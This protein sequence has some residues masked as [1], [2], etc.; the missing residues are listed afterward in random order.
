M[1]SR[2]HPAHKVSRA[3]PSATS[4][5]NGFDAMSEIARRAPFGRPAFFAP[6]FMLA[7]AERWSCKAG[8]P[9]YFPIAIV[10]RPVSSV[11][12]F[13]LFRSVMSQFRVDLDIFRGPLDL[14]LYLVRKHELD[15][16]DIRIAPSPSS[17]SNTSRCWSRSTSMRSAIFS[18]WPALLIEIKSRMVLPGD[19]EVAGGARRPAAGAGPPAA[20]VQAVPRRGQH[21]RRAQPRVAR[22][23]SAAG[24]RPAGAAA[25]A[26]RAADSGSRAVG[27]GERVRPRAEGEARGR[28][29]ENIRYDDTPIHVYMQRI[30][31]RLR[32]DGRV[33]FTAFF[34]D[35]VHKS[36][37]VGMFLA[38]LELVRHQHARAAQPELFGEIWLEP[39]DEAAAGGAGRGGRLR[40]WRAGDE[41]DSRIS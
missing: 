41:V 25:V 24:E 21:A 18:R 10:A 19:E 20:G 29:P 8:S 35:A 1:S 27:P 32:R 16:T 5:A 13:P 4:P 36:T 26:R 2:K 15:V 17:F 31:E 40:A 6:L 12:T 34:E 28:G 14:L 22:A 30:D 23:L 38:V 11:S 3:V 39:G 33:A 9:Y 37:L 7:S